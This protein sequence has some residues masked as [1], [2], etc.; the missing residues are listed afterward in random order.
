M[1]ILEFGD[2]TARGEGAPG[3]QTAAAPVPEEERLARSIAAAVPRNPR[4][5]LRQAVTDFRL[6]K[7][8]PYGVAPLVVFFVLD[9]V[10]HFD[11]T[12]AVVLL[13]E[14]RD[15][16]DVSLTTLVVYGQLFTV[17]G[18]P[19]ALLIGWATDHTR[20]TRLV[21]LGNVLS[22]TFS[23]L[24]GLAP[25]ALSYQA[26]TAL[27]SFGEGIN[28]SPTQSLLYDYYPL[29][30]RAKVIS[31]RTLALTLGGFAAPVAVGWFGTRYGWRACFYA[32]SPLL[33]LTGV[34][35][36][37]KLRE[38]VRGYWERLRAGEDERTARSEQ[39]PMTFGEAFR[40]VLAVKTVRRLLYLYPLSTL[41]AGFDLL[42]PFYYREAFGLDAFG[43]SL[44]TVPA[45]VA[46]LIALVVGGAIADVLLRHDPTRLIR[47][48]AWL[49]VA[50]AAAS[51]LAVLAGSLFVVVG[52]ALVFSVLTNVLRPAQLAVGSLVI[53]SRIRGQAVAVFAI[54]VLLSTPFVALPPYVADQYGLRTAL[55]LFAPLNI[56]AGLV[57]LTLARTFEL[58]ARAAVAAANAT[59][60]YHRAKEAGLVKLLVAR[61]VD[62]AYQGVQ[63]LFNV[64]VTIE[65][66]EMVALLGTN[67]AGKS[68]LLR[69][70]GGTQQAD[71]GAVL[72]DGRDITHAP[73]HE[74]ARMG[75]VTM[76]GG[77]AV[78]PS[79]SVQQNLDLAALELDD[80]A[81]VSERMNEVMTLFPALA[82]RADQPAAALSGGEQQMLGLAQAFLGRPRLLMIDELSLG[83]APA[84]VG[85]LLEVVRRMNDAGT[86][87]ILVEQS[88]NI[89]LTVCRRA[90]FMEKGEVRYDGPTAELLDRPDIM[91]A[92]YLKGGREAV[93]PRPSRRRG[94]EPARALLEADGI[95]L[96]YGGNRVLNDV[97]LVVAE[98]EAV[99]LIGPNGAGK[100]SLFDVISGFVPPD[101]GIVRF[102]G[103]DITRRRPE[104][105]AHLGLVRRFQDAKLFQSLTVLEAICVAL[106]RQLPVRSTF[107]AALQ[108]GAVRE[109]ER[110]I[111]R[112]ADQLIELLD[113]GQFRDRFVSE[114][115]T[116]VRRVVDLA[117]VLASEPRLVLLD[118]P[119]SG[120]AQAEAEGLGPLLR[121]IRYETGCSLL[122]IEHDMSLIA[123]VADELVA[124]DRGSVLTRGRPAAVLDHPGV[125][126]AYL[127]T[128]EAAIG[129]SGAT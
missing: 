19:L 39:P 18:V 28:D 72:F 91:R 44:I 125:V 9:Y 107:L 20:R 40:A 119:S 126:A 14:I 93:A 21:A 16:L 3:N 116:G 11:R 47:A 80:P 57:S 12:I 38:P 52:F 23:A 88:V 77:R 1:T 5:L 48:M 81:G 78:F 102:D 76:P 83:L 79:L 27:D 109:G 103:V 128:S 41:A 121:R 25:N 67:G 2:R 37:G 62:V 120:I 87:V 127:G 31:L 101:S 35:A 60:E 30:A 65:E 6:L 55:I 82:R 51:L 84:V 95:G 24:R 106:D 15:D 43:R 69:A 13:P 117:C 45:T 98:G 36:L 42:L 104:E 70:I 34:W 105:R 54:P 75:V 71:N 64:D 129:R 94:L 26:V 53:P 7:A 113:L 63:V 92:V 90:L 4:A 85:D 74:I 22:G 110:R 122:L 118:E 68:T 111:E 17:C 123:D 61:D 10:Q 112:R 89:A 29:E 100:T 66:G 73:P 114:L 124:L 108:V 33:V 99:G 56:L 96:S 86:T 50:A 97:E 58:D 32:T 59:N 8:T 49:R 46:G 115:S